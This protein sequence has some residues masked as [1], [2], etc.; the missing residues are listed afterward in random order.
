VKFRDTFPS[1]ASTGAVDLGYPA[2]LLCGLGHCVCL[3]RDSGDD[4][5]CGSAAA[6]DGPEYVSVLT[7][8][9]HDDDATGKKYFDFGD[10]VRTLAE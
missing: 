4:A 2:Q 8:V 1:I 7:F 5:K 9:G 3:D 10:I 6:T